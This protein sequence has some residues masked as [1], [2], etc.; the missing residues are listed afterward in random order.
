MK[1]VNRLLKFTVLALQVLG[2]SL[3]PLTN[4]LEIEIRDWH[5]TEEAFVLNGCYV[6]NVE[7]FSTLLGRYFLGAQC[8]SDAGNHRSMIEGIQKGKWSNKIRKI[9]PLFSVTVFVFY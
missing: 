1:L 5:W 7:T 6:A 2:I 9:E 3:E 8:F 4:A